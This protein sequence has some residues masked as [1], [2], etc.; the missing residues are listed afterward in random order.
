MLQIGNMEVNSISCLTLVN[1]M[2]LVSDDKATL[3]EID[4]LSDEEDS[5][6]NIVNRNKCFELD[7]ACLGFG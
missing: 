2:G 7:S 5:Q 1:Q 3:L 6:G 4:D